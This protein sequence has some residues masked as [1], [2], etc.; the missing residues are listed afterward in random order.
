MLGRRICLGDLR[1]YRGH[2]PWEDTVPGPGISKVHFS[3]AHSMK[4]S[5]I[6]PRPPDS[7]TWNTR[8]R[9]CFTGLPST[10]NQNK[11]LTVRS[12]ATIF[13]LYN[14]PSRRV[15]VAGKHFSP[16]LHDLL[17]STMHGHTLT[18]GLGSWMEAVPFFF[19]SINM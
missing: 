18:L 7:S 9:L 5:T 10:G 2:E 15:H 19:N 3:C 11:A 1:R 16:L 13:F 17:D 6:T 8:G 4:G 14:D 12:S